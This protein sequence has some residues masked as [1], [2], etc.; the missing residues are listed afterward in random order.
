MSL[1]TSIVTKRIG[2]KNKY[3]HCIIEH[4]TDIG[5]KININSGSWSSQKTECRDG[6]KML[7]PTG[8]GTPCVAWDEG[9]A[10]CLL[11]HLS[12]SSLCVSESH[13]FASF[14]SNT[15]CHCPHK[16]CSTPHFAHPS[17]RRSWICV[18]YK[19]EPI[20]KATSLVFFSSLT[21]QNQ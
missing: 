21:A 9:V 17:T 6:R 16:D 20:S 7:R 2:H 5:H 19:V 12:W 8:R 1:Y 10:Q 18:S 14:L 3:E 4:L 13:L 15:H 11:S